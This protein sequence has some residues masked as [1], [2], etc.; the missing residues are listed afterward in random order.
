MKIILRKIF[1]SDL[2]EYKYWLHPSHKYHHL[3]G[4]Y[5]KKPS[6][7]EIDQKIAEIQLEFELGNDDPLPNKMIISNPDND[8]QY[9]SHHGDI[10]VAFQKNLSAE[11]FLKSHHG[12]FFTEFDWQP[13]ASA[14]TE[15]S[16]GKSTRYVVNDRTAVSIGSGGPE[17]SFATWHGDIYL[18]ENDK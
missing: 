6:I 14:I 15:K 4:P 5:F 1:V 10:R 3:N 7:A 9:E 13:R 11:V 12:E 17:L 8:C 16:N 18:L 2:K